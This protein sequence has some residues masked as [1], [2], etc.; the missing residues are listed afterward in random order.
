MIRFVAWLSVLCIAAIAAFS[1]GQITLSF[2]T[3]SIWRVGLFAALGL[4]GLLSVFLF[5]PFENRRAVLL[6]IWIP[7]ILLRILLL[8]TAVSDDVSRYLFEGKL[9]RAGISPYAQTADAESIVHYRDVQWT[10]M[11]HKDKPTAYPP[12]AQLIFAAVG[13]MYYHPLA[14]KLM[15]VLADLLALGAVLRLLCRR[16]L[17]LAFSGF[18]ALNPVVLIAFAGEAHFDSLMIAALIWGLY[19]CEVGRT[20][21]AVA[22]ASVATG[23]KWVALPLIP[24]FTGKQLWLGAFIA[25]VTLVLPGIYFLE[26]LPELLHGLFAFGG[27]RSFNG[28]VYDSLFYGLSLSRPVCNGIALFVFLSVIFW[29]WLLRSRTPPDAHLRWILGTLIVVSPTAHFWYLAWVMPLICLRPSLPWLTF[30]VTAGSYFFV[31]VNAAGVLGWSLERWQQYLFWGPFA[32]SCIYEV[33]STKGRVLWPGLR[34]VNSSSPSI[35]VIIPTLNAEETLRKALKSIERQTIKVSEVI[36]V[37]AGSA[38]STLQIIDESLLPIRI[39]ASDPGRGIQ[40]AAGIEAA[41]TDW[42]LALHSDAELPLNA[43]D[44]IL[45]SVKYD[46]TIIGG[47]LG[48]R[49]QSTNARLLSIELLND[50]RALFTRTA[51]GDQAQFFHRKTALQYHLMPKQPL[52][53]DVESSW[54][55]REQGGFLF[56]NQPCQVSHYKWHPGGWFKRVYLVLRLV[57]KYRWARLRGKQRAEMLSKQLYLEYYSGKILQQSRHLQGDKN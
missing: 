29:R 25:V 23:I 48:Q 42:V 28:M 17:S 12:L 43:V 6:A 33:W 2:D 10:L 14:Y 16:G 57:S 31:W 44:C 41:A 51:F 30:S 18:Y 26:T 24:F 37:D 50:L 34:P 27:T 20:H 36:V 13:A 35:A 56:L 7:A 40:I 22:L 21:L 46:R 53:E 49:F 47:A 52:M 11:N 32:L 3:P 55:I 45:R 38:D 19:A 15:F 1:Y 5:P 39:L 54:R 9:V 8:P 4:T